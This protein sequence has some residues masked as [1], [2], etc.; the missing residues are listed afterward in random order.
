MT[1][2]VHHRVMRVGMLIEAFGQEDDRTE[3]HI[4]RPQKSLS[5]VL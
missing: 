1:L 3:V 5:S 2:P 4:G